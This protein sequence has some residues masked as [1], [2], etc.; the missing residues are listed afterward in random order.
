MQNKETGGIFRRLRSRL[1]GGE[2]SSPK[3]TATSS[4]DSQGSQAVN[5]DY[6]DR[7]LALNRYRKAVDELKEA[8]KI[9]KGPWVPFDFEEFN[10]QTWLF[11]RAC[12]KFDSNRVEQEIFVRRIESSRS[13]CSIENFEFESSRFTCSIDVRLEM[14]EMLE[15]KVIYIDLYVRVGDIK[16]Y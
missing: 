8:I 6:N 11:D 5:T 1:K 4:Q 13:H 10:D 12:S 7:R 9:R 14:F 16:G 2:T 3:T 15:K